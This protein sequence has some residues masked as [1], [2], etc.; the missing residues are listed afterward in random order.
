MDNLNGCNLHLEAL[1]YQFGRTSAR[2]VQGYRSADITCD[3][4]ELTWSLLCIIQPL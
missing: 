1:D 2:A 3:M 4:Y